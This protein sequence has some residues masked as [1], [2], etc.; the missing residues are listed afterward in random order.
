MEQTGD[1]ML[2]RYLRDL[3]GRPL[4]G[5]SEERSLAFRMRRARQALARIA[6]RIPPSRR[7][8]IV[9]SELD[10]AEAWMDGTIDKLEG[11]HR[12]LRAH[13]D[14]GGD[15]VLRR[16]A[17]RASRHMVRLR[18]ARESF[19]NG[20]LRLVIHIAKGYARNG[21]NL[22]D[23]IQDGNLGLMRAVE[24]YDPDRAIRFS[25]YASWWIRQAIQRGL[26]NRSRMI[27]VPEHHK[28]RRQKIARARAELR[29]ELGRRPTLQE[30]GARLKLTPE[31]LKEALSVPPETVALGDVVDGEDSPTLLEILPDATAPSPS[32]QTKR[33]ELKER[34][35]ESLGALG[36]REEE[37]IRLR[38]GLGRR[39]AHTLKEVGERL[40]L[41]R[42]RIRQ[43]ESGAIKML[44][45]ALGFTPLRFLSA[46]H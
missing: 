43:I 7:A 37:I 18:Q 21:I 44:K 9:G 15:A 27:R 45:A 13:A 26:H 6:V 12:R 36:G 38:F 28:E 33:R 16:L 34:L 32:G 40:N 41:S 42:E 4:L 31:M 39:R 1:R 2:R 14:A 5:I 30:I 8:V 10:S 3:H 23:L 17:D 20:N 35:E 22:L 19:I 46:E 25:S 11:F 24:K 29:E